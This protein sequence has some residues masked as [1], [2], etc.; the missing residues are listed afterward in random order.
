MCLIIA[1]PSAI[2]FFL[3]INLTTCKLVSWFHPPSL[4]FLGGG[5]VP[6]GCRNSQA[7]DGTPTTAV[8]MPDP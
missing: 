2:S 1:L 5:A 3:S 6:K 4:L 8:T 7:R